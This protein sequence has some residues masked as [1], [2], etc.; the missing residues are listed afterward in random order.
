MT[1]PTTQRKTYSS[2]PAFHKDLA[3]MQAAGWSVLSQSVERPRP[4]C[5]RLLLTGIIFSYVSPFK[6]KERIYVTYQRK[7]Q[8]DDA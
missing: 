7:E 2:H 5:I 8:T 3:K 6:V 1:Q 4:G